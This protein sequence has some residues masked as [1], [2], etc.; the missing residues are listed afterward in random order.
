MLTGIVGAAT[1]ATAAAAASNAAVEGA[2]VAAVVAAGAKVLLSTVAIDI[3]GKLLAGPPSP[4]RFAGF[5]GTRRSNSTD[6]S[7]TSNR[8]GALAD[9]PLLPRKR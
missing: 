8:V 3:G 7:N 5:F 2:T 4:Q 1:L 6:T 9:L